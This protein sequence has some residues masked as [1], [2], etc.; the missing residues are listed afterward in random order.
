[1]LQALFKKKLAQT[2]KNSSFEHSEDSK[3][4]SVFGLLQYLPS[5]TM[6]ELLQESCGNK[7]LLMEN[8]GELL[9]IYFWPK[10]SANGSQISKSSYVEPDV[11]CEFENFNLII[12]AKKDDQFGQYNQQW[13]REIKAYLKEYSD[14]PKKM[15]FLAFGGNRILES[16]K[17]NIDDKEYTI[18]RASWQRLLNAIQKSKKEHSNQI[19]RLFSDIILAFEKH[20]FFCLE[21]YETLPKKYIDQESVTIINSWK[22]TNSDFLNNFYDKNYINIK[23]SSKNTLSLWQTY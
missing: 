17:I 9:Q 11:F 13:E 1:M 10:W 4:S 21:W 18:L 23:N 3:T 5:Q 8:P 22:F 14:S 12:E 2:F 6:W 19:E 7:S 16:E 15:Y 20:N